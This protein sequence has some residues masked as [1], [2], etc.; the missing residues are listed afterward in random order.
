MFYFFVSKAINV[1]LIRNSKLERMYR[2]MKQEYFIGM[3]LEQACHT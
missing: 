3:C 1:G 2:D